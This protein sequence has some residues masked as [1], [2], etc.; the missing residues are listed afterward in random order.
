MKK[1]IVCFYLDVELK[2]Y[3]EKKAKENGVTLSQILRE[4]VLEKIVQENVA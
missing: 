4:M 3:L 2:E 1:E